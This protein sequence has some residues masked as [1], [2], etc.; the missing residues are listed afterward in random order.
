[1]TT[2]RA[3]AKAL[4]FAPL[5]EP[6]TRLTAEERIE[7]YRTVRQVW[8]QYYSFGEGRDLAFHLGVLLVALDYYRE[9]IDFLTISAATYEM[10]PGTAYNLSLCS[11]RIGELD[12]A[13]KLAELALTLDPDFDQAKTLR[14][15]I[16]DQADLGSEAKGEIV[17]A[18]AF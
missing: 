12:E 5:M 10:A 4:V 6:E 9:A 14:I 7:V 1:M 15:T 18:G 16:L 2:R 17:G 3:F 11:Y 13:L 8:D